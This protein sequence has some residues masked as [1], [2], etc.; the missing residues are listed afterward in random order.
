M[1]NRLLLVVTFLS[2]TLATASTSAL[3]SS[4][5]I[6]H[7]DICYASIFEPTDVFATVQYDQVIPAGLHVRINMETG[8]KEAKLLL[9]EDMESQDDNSNIAL[10]SGEGVRDEAITEPVKIPQPYPPSQPLP[11]SDI[12]I[13]DRATDSLSSSSFCTEEVK[14]ALD[15]LEELVHELELGLKLID[16]RK[17]NGL[18]RLLHF[19]Q[20]SSASQCRARAALVLGSSLRNNANAVAA[21]PEGYTLTTQLMTLLRNEHDSQSQKMLIYALS[22]TMAQ[23][24]AKQ[25]LDQ[26]DGHEVLLE[27]YHAGADDLKGKIAS[28]IED[29]FAQVDQQE[30]ELTVQDN[31]SYEH[32]LLRLEALGNWCDKFQESLMAPLASIATREKI[33]SAASQIKR[34]NIDAC[35]VSKDF[36]NYLADESQ[37][38]S[39]QTSEAI[40]TL[41]RSARSLFGNV[42]ASRKHQAGYL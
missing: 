21:L 8:L 24:R 18:E 7:G 15:T 31:K 38:K 41:A 30:K 27:A 26:M 9:P 34:A 1:W 22:A 4:K 16:Q 2:S 20:P 28:F 42:K 12:A 40:V 33:L 6:C 17:S 39:G 23:V 3:A 36:L 5:L 32:K 14:E 11:G 37:T 19:L 25:D 13:F 35:T 29:H 10:V